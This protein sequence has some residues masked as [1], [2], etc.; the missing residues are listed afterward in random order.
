MSQGFSI[1]PLFIHWYGILIMVGALGA[2]WLTDWQARRRGMDREMVWDMMPWLLIA[3]IVGARLWHIFTPPASMVAQGITVGYYLTHPLDALAIWRGGL[4][5]PG[6][7]MGGVVALILYTRNKKQS[8]W[9]WADMI[10]PGLA[11]A[12]AVGRWGNFVNQELYG[13]PTSLPWAIKIDPQYRL[14]GLEDVAYYH[15]LFLYE[16]IWNLLAMGVLLW[17][18]LKMKDRLKVGM[19]FQIYLI[20]YPIGRFALEF[21]RIDTSQIAGINFNQTLMLVIALVSAGVLIWR[22]RQPQKPVEPPPPAEAAE[23]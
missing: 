11:L 1:G 20:L 21:L 12:Q 9:V 13:L 5:I 7:V 18:A 4:G 2:A 15:P 17:L 16:S 14:P 22:L 23:I 10:A 3:G 8:F 19:I 6:A